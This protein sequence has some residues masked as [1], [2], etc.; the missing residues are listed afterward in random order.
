MPLTRLENLI[1]SK[2]GKYLYVSPD[3]F[4]ASDELDNRGNSPTRPFKTIQRAFIEVSRYSYSP[5][6]DNDRFDEF[7]IMLMPGEHFVDNRPGLVDE[8][9]I[10][11]FNF[12]QAL[13]AW[14]D[15]SVVDLAN[16]DNVLY[17]FN[18]KTGG[19]IV[20]RGCS[21]IGYD[22][23]RTVVRP[24]YVPDPADKDQPRTSIFNLTGGC[25]LWQFTIK[26]GDTSS[27]SPLF[28]PVVG[29]GKVYSSKDPFNIVSNSHADARNLI[30]A[31]KKFIAEEAVNRMLNDPIV[32]TSSG[33]QVPG[34]SVNCKD[35]V[36]D[37]LE[38][39]TYNLQYGGNDRVYEAAKLYL[40]GAHVAGEED[41]TKFVFEQ[42]R[43]ICIQV[44][45][46]E[47]VL[48]EPE[49]QASGL[50]QTKDLTI[51]VDTNVP[52]CAAV[53]QSIDTLW[54]VLLGAIGTS[55]TPG[56]IQNFETNYT[57]ITPAA[58]GLNEDTLKKPEYSHHKICI[59]IYADNE[60]LA[61]YYKKIAKAFSLYQPTIDDPGEFNS[62]VQENRIV[63]PLSDTRAIDE[64]KPTD[65]LTEDGT[66]VR[67]QV[68]T[69][70]DHGYFKGQFVAIANNGLDDELNGTFEVD[71][72]PGDPKVFTYIV[73]DNTTT[74]LGLI[75]NKIYS[76][77]V[78][79]EVS[80]N[81]FVQ[82]EIDSVESASPYVFNCSIRSTWGM[83]GMWAD[84]SKTTG[85][86]SMVVAQYTGVSLQKDDRAFIR[87]DE[88]SNTWNQASLK[89]AFGTV[90]YHTKGDAYWKDDW[91]NFH[92]RAS[93]D[94]FIQC[95][96]V[97]AVGFHDHFLMESGGDMSITNSNSN[98]GNTSLHAIG[99]KGY[100]FNQ[101]KG[102][103]ITDII[104]PQVIKD[105]PLSALGVTNKSARVNAKKLSYY[106]LDVKASNTYFG[107]GDPQNNHTKLYI[108]SEDAVDP[109]TR[110]AS[111]IDGFRIGART[112]DRIFVND[113]A[114]SGTSN[115]EFSAE[116]QP[117]GFR[118]FTVSL[119]TVN[120]DGATIDNNAQDAANRIED[121]KAFIQEQTYNYIITKYPDLLTN[122]NITIGKCKRDVGYI[123]DAVIQ[124]L[125]LSS[126]TTNPASTTNINTIQAAE[127]YYV[128]NSL[129][130]IDGEKLET[131]EAYDYTKNL[132]IAAM[133]NW[134]VMIGPV[135]GS[136]G[137]TASAGSPFVDVEDTRGLVIGMKVEQYQQVDFDNGWLK[138]TAVPETTIIPAGTYIKRIVNSYQIEL[139]TSGSYLDSGTTVNAGGSGSTTGMYL[140]FRLENGV[141]FGGLAP[142]ETLTTDYSILKSSEYR[143]CAG[144]AAAIN[145]YFVNIAL[146][147]ENGL[148]TNGV[149]TV[150]RVEP[151]VNTTQLSARTTLFTADIG[152]A[153]SNPHNLQTG[154]AVRLVPK[155]KAGT[156]PDKRV[157]R[158]PRGF[159][160]NVKYY[161]IAPG[162]TTFPK[163]YNDSLNYPGKFDGSDQTKFMLART[164]ENAC[165]GIY[166]YS[167]E[168]DSVHPDVEIEM[169]QFTLDDTYDLH[170]YTCN[171]LEISPGTTSSTIFETDV[172]HVFD[173]PTTETPQ[174]VF[175]RVAQDITGSTL[176]QLAGAGLVPT[177]Q[178][179]Y[180]RFNTPSTFTI[181]STP[182][183]AISGND[184]VDFVQNTGSN[185]YIFMD[186]RT[187][188]LRFD[189]AYNALGSGNVG[190]NTTGLWYL[191][192][193]NESD[194]ASPNF[195][196]ESI[197][198]RY[199]QPDKDD[200]NA[201]SQSFDTW[202]ERI[203]DNRAADQRIYRLR[204]VL[205]KDVEP[206]RKPLNGFAIKVR[207]DDTRRLLPQRIVLKPE[208]GAADVALFAN[209]SQAGEFLGKT[210]LEL[211]QAGLVSKY[212]P[213][214][215]PKI[216]ETNNYVAFSIQSARKIQ[217]NSTDYLELTVFDHTILNSQLKNE[218]FTTV[219]ISA[220]QGGNF[221]TDKDQNSAAAEVQ[222][223]GY[224]SGVANIHAY[225]S[226]SDTQGTKHYLI[227]KNKVAGE[228]VYNPLQQTTFS[229]SISGITI[230]ANLLSKPDSA[231]G[232]IGYQ[233][234]GQEKDPV[235]GYSKSSKKDYLYRQEGSNVYTVTPGDRI[236]DQDGGTY[237]VARVEDVGEIEDTFYIFDVEE[238][239]RRI[240][241]QTDGIYYLT[242]V[243]GNISPYP[244]GPGV[245]TNFHDYKFSQ[246]ISSLYPQNYKND[247]L[248]FQA[249]A[250]GFENQTITI[251]STVVDPPQ[252]LSAAD[253]Y[254]H[255][256]VRVNDVKSSLTKE[257][258]VDFVSQPAFGGFDYT[259]S[260]AIQAQEGNASQGSEQ[261]KIAITGNNVYPTQRKVYVEL[262]RPSIARSGN[263]TFEYLGFGPG[264]YS[265]GFP[266][267]QEVVLTDLQDFYAQA[268]REDA[269]IVFYTGLNSNG[270]LYIGNRKI[271]AITGEE[272]F[273][274]SAELLDSE[275]QTEDLGALVTT[276]Q[277]PVTFNDKITV[278]GNSFLNNS[279]E[280]NVDPADG[281]G[282][283]LR[284]FSN[285]PPITNNDP[286]L[287]RDR[288]IDPNLG[289]IVLNQNKIQSAIFALNARG[290][291][292]EPG[293]RYSFRTHLVSGSPS[294]V[295]P[296]QRLSTSVAPQVTVNSIIYTKQFVK[297]GT[298]IGNGLTPD[299]GDIILKGEEVGKTGSL[300]SIFT[301]YYTEIGDT[302]I[303]EIQA[304]GTQTIKIIWNNATNIGL[305]IQVGTRIRIKSFSG[306]NLVNGTWYAITAAPNA[307]F[308]EILVTNNIPTPQNPWMWINEPVDSNGFII[309]SIAIEQGNWKEVG[310]LGAETLRTETETWG[311]FKLGINT[312]ARENHSAY[313]TAWTGTFTEPRA[314]LDVTGNVFISGKTVTEAN[315]LANSN[316]TART[317]NAVDNALLVGGDY[318][319]PNNA[320]TFRVATTNSGRVGINVTKDQLDR[321]L[322]VAGNARITG[323]VKFE[324]DLEVNG[325][326][327]TTSSNIFNLIN[328]VNGATV[329]NAFGY[330]DSINIGDTASGTQEISIG[331][332]ANEQIFNIGGSVTEG[333]IY[334]HVAANRS[335]IKLAPVGNTTSTNQ[336]NITVGGAF[337]NQSNSLTNGSVFNVKN[338]YTFLDGD[339]TLGT[340]YPFGS[341]T[342]NLQTNTQVVN[343]FT[344]TVSTL[345]FA[346]SVGQL[347]LAADGGL[348]TI[349]NSL[350]V[351][352][353]ATFDSN[354]ILSGG[355]NSG[356]V[357]VAR[358]IWGTTTN[359]HPSGSVD[360]PN[361]DLFKKAT[362][363]NA[364]NI[365]VQGLTAWGGPNAEAEYKVPVAEAGNDYTWILPLGSTY[366]TN[367]ISVGCYLLI[368]RSVQVSG[369]NTTLSPVGEQ[370]SELLKVISLEN[371]SSTGTGQVVAV[372]VE[373]GQNYVNPDTG[374][375]ISTFIRPDH[376]DNAAIVRFDLSNNVSW[377]TNV[378]GIGDANNGAT[379]S[380]GVAEFGGTV[381]TGD[382][383]RISDQE[384]VKINS[385]SDTTIQS[386]IVNDGA[387]APATPVTNFSIESTTGN[388]FIRG[389]TTMENSL[390]INGSTSDNAQFLKITDG[391]GVQTF[392]VDSSTGNTCIR[393]NLGVGGANC[394]RFTV[395][396][397]NGST[398]IKGGDLTVSNSV[399]IDGVTNGQTKLFL[400]QSTG[401][402]KISGAY[403]STDVNGINTLAGD[404]VVNGGDLTV[405]SSTANVTIGVNSTKIFEINQDGSID[406]GGIAGYITPTG[407]RTWR[408]LNS[409]AGGADI[410]SNINYFIRPTGNLILLLPDNAITGDMIR[411]ID[412]GGNLTYNV[413]LRF[414]G[415]NGVSIQ[416]DDTN[417]GQYNDVPETN[418]VNG[419]HRN[420]G[421]LVVQTPNAG[422]GLVYI[423]ATDYLGQ[424]TQ[425]PPDSQGW[426]LMEV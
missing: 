254:T 367:D 55:S 211:S 124:D 182:A 240:S 14:D 248:W 28:D 313:E 241:G 420:G 300:G 87:Y 224:S 204:Y 38:E 98:F 368:D 411:I 8:S 140:H 52:A 165:S 93:N 419:T 121:N 79:G 129:T 215:S 156:N 234:T 310:V 264:N 407:G 303:S 304:N 29:Y 84:G 333:E 130:Y 24:L 286:S 235:G 153:S 342:A 245:G 166:I 203:N 176:P 23:R 194:P 301:N 75:N 389:I 394:D 89:D 147:I 222:W 400:Q 63:G 416:G 57:K 19:A 168:T 159:E 305:N 379:T 67:I 338:R 218:I 51:T 12:N 384:L 226:V 96:S 43:D 10:G 5:G 213:Y 53:A 146:I 280:I 4:N 209:P 61:T 181:H 311:N 191:N 373:R 31:N 298:S 337:A 259:G 386:F 422:L 261:R 424:S 106:T 355:L 72:L 341:N 296:N 40:T 293:Q 170:K 412:I 114:I 11:V 46:N 410:Q 253:N 148:T 128:G 262:R 13:N 185:F 131:L 265:T 109:A 157:I 41:Q 327:L 17:K 187:S 7:T 348:T 144:I 103:Y 257:T 364:I 120:P 48:L 59:M 186:K 294:N 370:Y 249:Q 136:A 143:E 350:R 312:I 288:W 196:P 81:A 271:N 252:T 76:S 21:L 190:S 292:Q 229:Q 101:D 32:G 347:S 236:V 237:I 133:R 383:L 365:D 82:A 309:A 325:G 246:P 275:D 359:S 71:S 112:N 56:T 161:I 2:S 279:V 404:L 374:I 174:K 172:P 392:Y 119:E 354:I 393:G 80:P 223:T 251:D 228:I 418:T 36:E 423:G 299:S 132:C 344:T 99:H 1:S 199:H 343:L 73:R 180:A 353:T 169:Y 173:S 247:P 255:G 212:D 192:V 142:T 239:Q 85:F 88:F 219:E 270:D 381:T 50:V 116:L 314:N 287:S 125:R 138:S 340:G 363:T 326:N 289:D 97:F 324:S 273:L 227:L 205:P 318:I 395:E 380:I 92:I 390:I 137:C 158:L 195:R 256:L 217:E 417:T 117:S 74:G 163:D 369:Q 90:A 413:T 178:Y 276:F 362:I 139:G 66:G 135:G 401:N 164:K 391:A 376:P 167:S 414:R 231:G 69:K 396:A 361:I 122:T 216:V 409:S 258:V 282:D 351:K 269:G 184:P 49:T 317:F 64:I 25:Y 62:R 6:L 202:F 306:N 352:A 154:T 200:A 291:T 60:D 115:T 33:F 388:T 207:T 123:V 375:P 152:N 267:R 336:S 349:N 278:E 210:E 126:D 295:S 58:S 232:G 358:G 145:Q 111:T 221:A 415:P 68:T 238:V 387:T 297:Y 70:I 113:K 334:V 266:L 268:K 272:T 425:A 102:G 197:L 91:R 149:P 339:L 346:R 335:T 220:P 189:A 198:Y 360:N 150:A 110:P 30:L 193:K 397:T 95:V 330:G 225:T 183:D 9:S 308:C 250:S 382:V 385:L 290:N 44:M 201:P 206:V 263:H 78:V 371:P 399:G 118:K 27:N 307:S 179:Y 94:S 141:P 328:N 83:C 230:T 283:A 188:P 42:A 20:P 54:S 127:S 281:E 105:A 233:I 320:A 160:P 108:G 402:L 47:N 316:P 39:L 107:P 26:D 162:R 100:A 345:N 378:G 35:D 366:T 315:F 45:R 260:N 243:R 77:T 18:A 134:D 421:E 151:S 372:R 34:G 377:I 208:G 16:P 86:R 356:T 15:N 214:V 22:L 65:I 321:T 274:E 398:L 426:W 357:V 37:I 322:V 104:P 155:A 177:Q 242:C 302:T 175:F 406:A 332:A 319:S 277:T 408:F 285:V 403:T 244:L 284:I 329:I 405:N 323:A 3:D 171:L 331:N